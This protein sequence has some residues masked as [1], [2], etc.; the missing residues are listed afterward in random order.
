MLV[1]ILA[2]REGPGQTASLKTFFVVLVDAKDY[3]QHAAF[4][5]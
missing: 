5:K 1:G 4:S 2:N 3:P